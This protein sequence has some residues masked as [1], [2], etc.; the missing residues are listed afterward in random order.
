MAAMFEQLHDEGFALEHFG[1]NSLTLPPCEPLA[2]RSGDAPHRG[3]HHSYSDVIAARVE[4]SGRISR[5]T[6]QPICERHGAAR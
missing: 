6:L 3:P 5:C 4:G 1:R 2:L